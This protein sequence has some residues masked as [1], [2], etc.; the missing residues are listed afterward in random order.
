MHS[1]TLLMLLI[2]MMLMHL[3]HS[4][5]IDI[6]LS[7]GNVFEPTINYSLKDF[8]QWSFENSLNLTELVSEDGTPPI[9]SGRVKNI[10]SLEY[11]SYIGVY[12]IEVYYC[13]TP[14]HKPKDAPS[15]SSEMSRIHCSE[16]LILNMLIRCFQQSKI[17]KRRTRLC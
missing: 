7:N 14:K 11:C 13:W 10:L 9:G 1:L 16:Y 2:V 12:V 3:F 8:V 15:I 6:D 4:D 5:Y 17:F